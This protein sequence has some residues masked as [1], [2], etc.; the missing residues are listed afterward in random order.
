MNKFISK[1][2]YFKN[3][4]GHFK[5][6]MIHK[7]WVFR[8]AKQLGIP[9]QGLLHDLSKFSWTEFSESVKF[10]QEGKSSPII[11]AKKAQGY[12]L[13]WQHHKGRNPHHYEHWTDKYDDGT[14]A[15][16][17][18][19]KYAVEMIA[20]Y[21]GAARGYNGSSFTLKGEYEWW[22]NRLEECPPKMHLETQYFVSYILY[23][24]SKEGLFKI[25]TNKFESLYNS[26]YFNFDF[27]NTPV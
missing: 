21:L 4:I 24:F 22:K 27:E 3:A 6:I 5:T 16:K 25:N 20:D 23:R 26:G 1:M 17:M 19:F 10:Y 7:Y 13:A 18:P 2:N 9:Y 8:Y 15:L 12:S 14:I 11:A